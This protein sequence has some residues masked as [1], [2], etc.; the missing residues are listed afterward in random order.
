[1]FEN[2]VKHG[3]SYLVY[4]LPSWIKLSPHDNGPIEEV[5]LLSAPHGCGPKSL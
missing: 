1:V 4:Y 5:L 2:V 3:I